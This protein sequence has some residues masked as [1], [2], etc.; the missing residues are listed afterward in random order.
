[1]AFP[2]RTLSRPSALAGQSNGRLSPAILSSTPGL[3]GGL[4]VQLVGP[5]SRAW[6]ALSAAALGAGHVLKL[7]GAGCGYRPYAIQER[8]FRERYTTTYLR[9]RPY[10]YWNG[11]RWYQKAGTA[12]AAVPGTSNHG[13]GL[14]VDVGEE[15][16]SDLETEPLDD[17]TL[18]WLL[19]N[20]ERFGFSHEV[21]SEPWHLRY[22]AGDRTPQAVLDFEAAPV[23]EEDD[24]PPTLRLIRGQGA[25]EVFVTD[26][27]TK[28]Y[29]D[30]ARL[31]DMLTL[32][33]ESPILASTDVRVVSADFMDS[34]PTVD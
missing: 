2:V 12:V 18:A 27:I 21:Q 33:G 7:S 14:A 24:M 30:P 17:P 13:W 1:M 31:A 26:F 22:F 16:D 15:R 19:A 23:P 28:R 29:L 8:I 20:E 25:A 3:A 10:R 6:R 4:E 34:I 11:R 5:A 32:H 9:G